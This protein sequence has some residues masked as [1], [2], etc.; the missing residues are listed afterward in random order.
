MKITISHRA[1]IDG[2]PMTP[3]MHAVQLVDGAPVPSI[4]DRIDFK[5]DGRVRISVGEPDAYAAA[6]RVRGHVTMRMHT[7]TGV[8][9]FVEEVRQ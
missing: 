3:T 4:G 7:D 9:L 1:V 5:I 8:M 6:E 2:F